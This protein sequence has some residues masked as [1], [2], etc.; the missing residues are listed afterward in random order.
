MMKM[1]RNTLRKRK[2]VRKKRKKRKR[3]R[4]RKK[5]RR[6]KMT[7]RKMRTLCDFLG[8]IACSSPFLVS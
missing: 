2:R 3:K 7:W 8:R 4:K 1:K 6:L 5:R